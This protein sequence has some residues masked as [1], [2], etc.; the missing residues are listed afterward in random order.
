MRRSWQEV[1]THLYYYCVV[2]GKDGMHLSKEYTLKACAFLEV[3]LHCA[4]H[5]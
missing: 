3:V 1:R 2:L 5:S 4:I